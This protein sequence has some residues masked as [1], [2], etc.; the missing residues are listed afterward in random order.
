MPDLCEQ[1]PKNSS[2]I[3]KNMNTP[4]TNQSEVWSNNIINDYLTSF[5]KVFEKARLHVD[6]VRKK[7]HYYQT[8]LK[9]GLWKRCIYSRWL[10]YFNPI[11]ELN[12]NAHYGCVFTHDQQVYKHHYDC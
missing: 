9:K 11:M 7:W 2:A 4:L 12:V 8:V 5:F 3:V 1:Y 10:N 6:L